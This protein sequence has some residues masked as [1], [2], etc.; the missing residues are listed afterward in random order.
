M[1]PRLDETI[2]LGP[3]S[4]FGSRRIMSEGKE[5]THSDGSF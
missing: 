5:K 3:G 2:Q 1:K 4:T